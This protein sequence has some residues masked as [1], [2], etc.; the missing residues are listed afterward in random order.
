MRTTRLTQ[1]L[2]VLAALLLGSSE[3]SARRWT[4]EGA[5]GPV[6]AAD[7]PNNSDPKA[8]VRMNTRIKAPICAGCINPL[9]TKVPR[10]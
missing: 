4:E 10:L 5:P 3:R 7:N 2:P 9:F 1:Y 8:T 6:A